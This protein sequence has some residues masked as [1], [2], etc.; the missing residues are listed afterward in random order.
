MNSLFDPAIRRKMLPGEQSCIR[1]IQGV[2]RGGSGRLASQN[3]GFSS[4]LL[5]RASSGNRPGSSSH[6]IL[7]IRH[8]D[9][10]QGQLLFN[11]PSHLVRRIGYSANSVLLFD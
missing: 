3:C 1:V 5:L 8:G 11:F 2:V 9:I 7:Q 4:K 6:I 10:D